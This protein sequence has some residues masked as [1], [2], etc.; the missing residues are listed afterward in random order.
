MLFKVDLESLNNEIHSLKNEIDSLKK[1]A[2]DSSNAKD[3]V[4]EAFQI[5][6]DEEKLKSFQ[7]N[8]DITFDDESKK[9]AVITE[10]CQLG[11]CEIGSIPF[12][13]ELEAKHKA[14]ELTLK[15]EKPTSSRACSS[16][17]S[18]YLEMCI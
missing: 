14:I 4:I 9:W 8:F 1:L 18:E 12:K 16:C 6:A 7:L 3:A 13:N 10:Y 5:I 15:N 17:Y 11:G 2:T